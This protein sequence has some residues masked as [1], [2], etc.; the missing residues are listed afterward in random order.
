MIVN[1]AT[2]NWV[3]VLKEEAPDAFTQ[4]CRFAAKCAVL[5]GMPMLMAGGHIEVRRRVDYE[6]TCVSSFTAMTY[7]EYDIN[8]YQCHASCG[9][10]LLVVCVIMQ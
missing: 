6:S 9:H 5:D 2:G 1:T 3:K 10:S 7:E 4:Q 8:P